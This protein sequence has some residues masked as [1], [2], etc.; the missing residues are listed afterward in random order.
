MVHRKKGRKLSRTAS[1]R[2]ALLSNLS[3]SLILNKRIK[4]TEAKAKELRRFIEPLVAKAKRALKYQD[5]SPE[6]G[7]HL[8]REARKFLNHKEALII[9]FDEIGAKVGDRPGGFTRVLKTGNRYGDGAKTA[10]IEFVDYNYIKAKEEKDKEKSET[11][12]AKSTS[13]ENKTNPKAKKKETKTSTDKKPGTEK[14]MKNQDEKSEVKKEKKIKVK[15]AGSEE[16][17]TEKV[18]KP[19]SE[20]KKNKDTN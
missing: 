17:K 6:R 19:K 10:I 12:D 2:N 9:L 15:G 3:I 13:E 1:H 4:T 5:S 8:R 16:K 14:K 18:E 7:I 11:A 20:T